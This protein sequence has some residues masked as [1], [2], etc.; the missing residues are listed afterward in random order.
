MLKLFEL[1]LDCIVLI[2]WQDCLYRGKKERP[3]ENY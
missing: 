1:S 3:L 2:S